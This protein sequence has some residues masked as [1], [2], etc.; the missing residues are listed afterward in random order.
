[1][2]GSEATE[3]MGIVVPNEITLAQLVTYCI[4]PTGMELDVDSAFLWHLPRIEDSSE[5]DKTKWKVEEIPDKIPHGFLFKVKCSSLHD[6]SMK[7]MVHCRFGSVMMHFS[8]APDACLERLKSRLSAWMEAR[9][10]GPDWTV[11]GPDREAVDFGNVYEVIPRV[12][13]VPVRVFLKQLEISV[14]P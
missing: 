6:G 5:P 12:Q 8:L 14:V 1:M 2:E 3:V 7:Q 4:L 10:Q 13:E 9:G 11:E